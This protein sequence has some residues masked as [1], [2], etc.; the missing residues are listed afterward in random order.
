[1]QSS[2]IEARPGWPVTPLENA[3]LDLDSELRGAAEWRRFLLLP[4]TNP[5]PKPQPVTVAPQDPSQVAAACRRQIVDNAAAITQ[6][7]IDAANAGSYQAAKFLFEFAGL[8]QTPPPVSSGPR[9]SELVLAEL[10]RILA[11]ES[12]SPQVE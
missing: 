4:M 9:P 11:E 2:E 12:A 1:M 3:I 7:L 8:T 6:G 10:K 5:R